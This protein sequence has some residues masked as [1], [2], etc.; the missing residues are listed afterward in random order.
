MIA[1]FGGAFN[2]P[3]IA[4]YEVA[5]HILSLPDVTKLLF[6]PVGDQYEKAGLI[7]AFHRAKMLEIM[8]N[9]L[10]HASVSTVEI[11]ADRK[12][13]TIETLEKLQAKYPEETLVFVMGAD[14]LNDLTG[15]YNY[16]QLVTR[17][18]MI[19]INRG[20]LD[21]YQLIK[22]HFDFAVDNFL[23]IDDFSKVDIS[24]SQY[25]QDLRRSDLLRS[26]VEAYIKKYNLY[27][28]VTSGWK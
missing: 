26:E 15:W 2:P 22:D 27:R 5:K 21:V 17:F 20:E 23:I 1:I 11:E 19:I 12:L 3:T 14:N 28:C 18:K 6:V 9:G 7:P 16:Q 10:S 8:I 4:H 24:S 25:R 13:K